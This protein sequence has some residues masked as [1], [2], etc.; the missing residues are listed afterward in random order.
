[1]DDDP[2]IDWCIDRVLPGEVLVDAARAA[3]DER[4]TNQPTGRT[5]GPAPSDEAFRLAVVTGKLWRPGRTLRVAFIGGDDRL[6]ARVL[7]HAR[8]W[9]AHAYLHF[10]QVGDAEEAEIRVGFTRAG[11][12][13]SVG[14]DA[15]K[16]EKGDPTMNLQLDPFSSEEVIR[17][18]TLHE[19]GH[20]LGSLHEH[21]SGSAE[22]PWN[23]EAVY[24]LYAAPPNRWDRQTTAA[25]ILNHYTEL[26]SQFSKFD[27]TSIM[28]YPIPKTLT[29]GVFE[30]AWNTQLSVT[31]RTFI[32]ERY[33][34][35][36]VTAVEI[37]VGGAGVAGAI[38]T[39][40][41]E[42]QFEFTIDQPGGYV[43]A[44]YGYQELEAEL[45]GPDD[46]TD[47]HAADAGSGPTGNARIES[48]LSRGHYL[49]RVRHHDPAAVGSYTIAVRA[50][51]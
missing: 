22:I 33:P 34:K 43:V 28:I 12:W 30:V 20:V 8:Q 38:G 40:G 32:A 11:H 17:R 4:E 36:E 14:T 41:A 44:T 13:S 50:L 23:R 3:L 37:P 29:D 5:V 16:V 21:Q 9:L 47:R 6:R 35:V 7:D 24:Q 42:N 45:F 25:N 19:F 49:V 39:P 51:T 31:D 1:M 15:L 48:G 27:P 26:P 46:L 2:T 18:A 10:E